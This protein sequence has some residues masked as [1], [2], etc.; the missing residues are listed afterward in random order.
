M[1]TAA[2]GVT[3]EQIKAYLVDLLDRGRAAATVSNRFR[4]LQ[5][6]FRFLVDEGKSAPRRWRACRARGSRTSPSTS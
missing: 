2:E 5:Q 4:A 1:P 6:L 3:R